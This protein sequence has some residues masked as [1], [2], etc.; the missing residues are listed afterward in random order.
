MKELIIIGVDGFAREVA[1]L[2][3]RIN[4]VESTW[5]LSGYLVDDESERGELING[6]PVLGTTA[7]IVNH[8]NAWY[9]CAIDSSAGRR[10]M[11]ERVSGMLDS[12]RFATLVDPSA[13]MS[14]LVSVGEGSIICANTIATVNIEIGRHVI[15]NLDCTIGHDAVLGDFVTLCPSVNISGNTYIGAGT[16]L[17]MGS[18]VIEK[19]TVGHDTVVGAGA[20]VVRDLPDYCTAVGAPAKPIISRGQDRQ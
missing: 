15:S 12:I 9:I 16:E 20:V 10:Q 8:P 13:L 6:Y 11:V 19:K 14:G 4:H 17:G 5:N 7:D 3:E 2:V 18:Q 1:W